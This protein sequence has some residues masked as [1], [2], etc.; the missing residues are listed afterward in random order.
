MERIGIIRTTVCHVA[1]LACLCWAT[2]AAHAIIVSIDSTTTAPP[3]YLGATLGASQFLVA[4]SATGAVALEQW[5]FDLTFDPM[6]VQRADVGGFHQGVFGAEFNATNPA[7]SNILSSGFDLGGL[8]DDV[9][10]FA[11]GVTGDGLLAYIGFEYLAGQ[12]GNNPGFEIGGAV[13]PQPVPEPGSLA[14]VVL[15]LG[16]LARRRDIA[17]RP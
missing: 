5:Q 4:V 9:A 7:P 17:G 1:V 11:A 13:V 3:A 2:P 16:I 14:L 12:E 10:G 15:G 8:L 6:I